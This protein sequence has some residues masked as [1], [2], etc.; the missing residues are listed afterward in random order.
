VELDLAHRH[1]QLVPEAQRSDVA[2]EVALAVADAGQR[3]AA[4]QDG[5]ALLRARDCVR[6]REVEHKVAA[7]VCEP[8]R[9]PRAQLLLQRRR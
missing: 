3:L 4:K 1:H 8:G 6:G 5:A 7:A 9:Q 2:M